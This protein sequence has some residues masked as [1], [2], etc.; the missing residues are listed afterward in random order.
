M[1]CLV[2]QALRAVTQVK[3]QTDLA[4][5]NQSS[6]DQLMGLGLA[7]KGDPVLEAPR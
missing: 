4:L 1:W 3:S 7:M 5:E 2:R 6:V